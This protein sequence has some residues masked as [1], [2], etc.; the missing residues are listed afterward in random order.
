MDLNPLN[1]SSVEEKVL[2]VIL[3]NRDVLAK[4]IVEQVNHDKKV[5]Y[6]NLDKLHRKGL[7]TS[8]VKERAR[9][10]SFAGVQAIRS[11]FLEESRILENRKNDSDKLI[12]DIQKIIPNKIESSQTELLLGKKS[13][14]QFLLNL[15]QA[16]KD[17]VVIGAP[18]ESL[19][20]FGKTFWHNFHA[21]QKESNIRARMIF[22]PSLKEGWDIDNPNLKVRYFNVEPLTET[23]IYENVVAIIVWTSDPSA[24]IIKNKSVAQSYKHFFELLWKQAKE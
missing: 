2:K 9:H 1:L 24:T 13:I 22:N 11:F 5:V 23:I 21:K 19:D 17:Y 4:T 20:V 16:T 7:I 3:N 15:S 10:Y 6:D 12:Q 18:Y 14:R 8:V